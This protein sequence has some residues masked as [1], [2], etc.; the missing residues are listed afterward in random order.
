MN[1][2]VLSVIVTLATLGTAG[3]TL[4]QVRYPEPPAVYQ[5]KLRYIAPTAREQRETRFEEMLDALR[6]LGAELDNAELLDAN[7]LDASI[8]TGKIPSATAR[9]ALAI[10]IVQT[11]LLLP[12][13][14]QLPQID[15][16]RV[17]VN[18]EL[19][20][21]LLPQT[22]RQLREQTLLLLDGLAFAPSVA[23]DHRSFTRIRGTIPAELLDQLL[24]DLRTQPLGWFTPA[25][26]TNQL[27]P[28]IRSNRPIR[29]ITV[30]PDPADVERG[31]AEPPLPSIPPEQPYLLKLAPDARRLL[32]GESER[33][34]PLRVEVIL[35]RVPPVDSIDWAKQLSRAV[36]GIIVDGNAGAVVSAVLPPGV[37]LA[38]AVAPEFVASVRLPV[39][40][41]A[42]FRP[43]TEQP[44]DE[45]DAAPLRV[46]NL[47][48]LHARG[49]TGNGVQVAVI[50]A[51]FSGYADLVGKSLPQDTRLIDLTV[52]STAD[53]T[54]L[55]SS[56][57]AGEVAP[58]T[59]TAQ[60]LALA[61]PQAKLL[62]LRVDPTRPYQLH[63]LARWLNNQPYTSP[64][65][66]R[67]LVELRDVADFY[68]R[69]REELVKK[70]TELL[71]TFSDSD[72][73]KTKL[74]ALN[75]ELAQLDGEIATIDRRRRTLLRLSDD[76]AL[77][78][79]T[80]V[81]ANSLV[82]NTGHPLNGGSELAQELDR[83]FG[84]F[85]PQ[86]LI[87]AQKRQARLLW[88]QSAGDTR[89]QSWAGTF[90]DVD[91]NGIMEFATFAT[92]RRP[93]TW[94]H[95]LNFI[96][97]AT[98]EQKSPTLELPAKARVRVTVQW[99]EP[100]DP[101]LT[102]ERDDPYRE[103]VAFVRLTALRQLD[104]EGK[105]LPSDDCDVVAVSDGLPVRIEQKQN[106][107]VYEQS[108]EFT[109]Q[110]AGRFAVQLEALVPE[111][112]RP[113][114]VPTLEGQRKRWELQLRLFVEV[115]DEETRKTG[116]A[117]WLDYGRE[118]G[119]V[120]MPGD[121]RGVITVGAA[122]A[123]GQPRPY[124]ALLAGAG[125]ELLTRPEVFAL[126]RLPVGKDG[127]VMPGTARANAFAAGL[128]ATVLSADGF[129][130]YFLDALGIRPGGL[131]VV[132]EPWIMSWERARPRR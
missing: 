85:A 90:R 13:D 70:R 30:I 89:G 22:Q 46:T 123:Q 55:P 68:V 44:A 12:A 60:A 131:L 53:N 104:P 118:G 63:T 27:P 113:R 57:A 99:S 43:L 102:F 9:Q 124:T 111:T 35:N 121:A 2:V 37:S 120:G 110:A 3:P 33:R 49:R 67:T 76:L 84:V 130:D 106:L 16:A 34:E 48:R 125:I 42:E 100:H 109:A 115:I 51:D 24:I 128:A 98:P 132:P 29:V 17:K 10:P 47:D 4:A 36:P 127:A 86:A 96:G 73:I 58:G 52:L 14:Y 66:Q 112:I 83:R 129:Q 56:V 101:T 1:R 108:V 65:V 20:E 54:P 62:L 95:E 74:D 28:P 41:R 105:Q 6:Q 88:F 78:P 114:S 94:T 23:Y 82:W 19:V 26:L 117:V 18:L 103:S 87:G 64:G 40:G 59:R 116:Q 61:A 5:F 21:G 93:G 107:G 81:V 8:I 92:P 39:A 77:L 119:G 69:S 122:D 31:Q 25:T 91:N 50:D 38:E 80:R 11:L 126:D 7:D 79:K 15:G 71:D 75:R 45:R 72:E 97:F 32:P